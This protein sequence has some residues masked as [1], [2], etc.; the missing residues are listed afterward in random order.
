MAPAEG[1]EGRCDVGSSSSSSSSG[2]DSP[3]MNQGF[4]IEMFQCLEV[5]LLEAL[6]LLTQWFI[7]EVIR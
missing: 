2:G 1:G 6:R 7:C 3:R 4:L 5:K